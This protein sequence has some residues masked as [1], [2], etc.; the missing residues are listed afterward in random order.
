[1]VKWRLQDIKNLGIHI[2]SNGIGKKIDKPKPKKYP[3]Q[4]KINAILKKIQ[5]KSINK[6]EIDPKDFIEFALKQSTLSFV[7]EY[8]FDKERKFRFDWAL[9]EFKYYFEYD[10]LQSEK[11]GHTT[12]LGFT[13]DTEK[14]ALATDLGWRGK[15][16]TILNY[17]NI[18][19]DL[20]ILRNEY[21][22]RN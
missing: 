17:Q 11:S 21:D 2:D 3:S 5:D 1:M 16:Y 6:I 19:Q 12:L 14:R 4:K 22:T 10:G 20:K 9:P 7:K 8:Q 13:K 18:V 15:H